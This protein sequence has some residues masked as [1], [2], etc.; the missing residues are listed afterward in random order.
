MTLQERVNEMKEEI[1]ASRTRLINLVIDKAEQS[2]SI[3][4]LIELRATYR[5]N[6]LQTKAMFEIY[7]EMLGKID[8]AVENF[9]FGNVDF[10]IA[11]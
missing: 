1:R 3:D 10:E 4:K 9:E 6:V 2:K 8:A 7:E 11:S 5:D